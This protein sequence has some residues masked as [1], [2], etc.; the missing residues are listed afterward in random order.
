MRASS[1][2]I[3]LITLQSEAAQSAVIGGNDVIEQQ[4]PD[5]LSDSSYKSKLVKL[6]TDFIRVCPPAFLVET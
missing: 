6:Q 1:D 4:K 5:T 3:V 2:Y